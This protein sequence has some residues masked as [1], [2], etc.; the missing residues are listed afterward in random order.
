[1]PEV[2]SSSATIQVKLPDGSIKQLP[3]GTTA[4]EVAR[5]ISPRLA[6]AAIVAQ[7]KPFHA[8][9]GSSAESIPPANG[10]QVG[11]PQEGDEPRLIDLMRPL[12]SDVELRI[13]TEKDP[14]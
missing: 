7:A 6:D 8:N 9:G 12:E 11:H 4:L 13:L 2:S 1:M 3:K 5:S 10:A 14:E